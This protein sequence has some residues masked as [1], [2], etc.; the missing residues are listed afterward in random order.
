MLGR[1]A[2]AQVAYRESRDR[3]GANGGR[4][5]Y[6]SAVGFGSASRSSALENAVPTRVASLSELLRPPSVATLRDVAELAKPRITAMVLF[7][8]AMGYGF[9]PG[10]LPAARVVLLLAGTAL[11]VASANALNSWIERDADAR[12]V[13]TRHRPLPGGRL[14]PWSAFALALFSAVVAIPLLA[15]AVGPKVAALGATAHLL[16]VAVYTPLK[17]ITPWALEI[18][19]VPGAIPPLMGS[20]AATGEI[21]TGGVFLFAI[22]FFWQ[23]PHF[24]AIALYLEE[25]Y[26]RGGFRVLPVATSSTVARRRLVLYAALLAVVGLAAGPLGLAGRPYVVAA[27]VLGLG[28]VLVAARGLLP[29]TGAAWARRAMLATLVHLTALIVALV[30]GAS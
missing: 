10:S 2:A 17:R 8:T 21:S 15:V 3:F 7:T 19:A 12:M 25:D 22:L 5:R 1:G 28:F 6:S 4:L 18:G 23:L 20:V 27:A 13:R 14:D 9:A 26:R 16:Y 24:L 30:L 11:L 29:G